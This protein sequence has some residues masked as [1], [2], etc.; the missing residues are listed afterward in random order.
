MSDSGP[1]RLFYETDIEVLFREALERKGLRLGIDFAMQYPLRY[2]FILDFAFPDQKIAIEVDGTAYH[3]S[4][5]ARKRDAF[6]NMILEKLGWK[7][8][9]FWDHEIYDSLDSCI[10]KVLK[11]LF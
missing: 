5:E 1:Q 11:E 2:S 9:R 4:R 3:T 6:K 7:V 8:F 10:N